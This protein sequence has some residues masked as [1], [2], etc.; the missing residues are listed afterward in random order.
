MNTNNIIMELRPYSREVEYGNV[1]YKR[2]ISNDEKRLPSLI[3]QL[4]WRLNEGHGEAIYMVGLNDNGSPYKLSQIEFEISIET[5]SKMCNVACAKIINIKNII[6]NECC[7]Y[8]VKI[9]SNS[10]I[11]NETRIL[12]IGKNK[13]EYLSYMLY[14]NDKMRS[15]IY[16]YEHEHEI[17]I[18]S[19][20]IGHIGYDDNGILNNYIN[21][22]NALE[23]KQK[24]NSI[25]VFYIV[26]NNKS[27]D[28]VYKYM[29]F[30]LACTDTIDSEIASVQKYNVPIIF[31][32]TTI[33]PYNLC[34]KSHDNILKKSYTIKGLVLLSVIYHNDNKWLLLVLNNSCNI[35]VGDTFYCFS[36]INNQIPVMNIIDMRYFDKHITELNENVTFTVVVET[37]D[38][39]KKYKREVFFKI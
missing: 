32:S 10:E 27:Y 1:E 36:H 9:V 23:I 6:C 13:L 19:L 14:G 22:A 2:K 25:V 5:L 21:C 29:N 28:N 33:N 35:N 34:M 20:T 30:I 24:S 8:K 7:I 39:L 31:G 16:K 11:L 26:P 18:S 3:T 17:G 38:D 12:L 15:N 4:V 37:M